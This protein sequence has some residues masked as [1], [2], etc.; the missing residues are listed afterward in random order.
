MVA[1]RQGVAS[2]TLINSDRAILIGEP[3]SISFGGEV[4]FAGSIDRVRI[5]TMKTDNYKAYVCECVDHASLMLRNKITAN[6]SNITVWSLAQS[7]VANYLGGDGFTMG[8]SPLGVALPTVDVENIS[9]YDMLYEAAVSVGGSLEIT[10]DKVINFRNA[11]PVPAPMVIDETIVESCE[12][13]FDRERYRNYQTVE[14]TGTPSAQG[15]TVAKVS[16]TATI[17]SQISKQAGIEGTNGVYRERESITHPSSNDPGKLLQLAFAYANTLLAVNGVLSHTVTV[18]VRKVGFRVGQTAT[19]FLPSLGIVGQFFIRSLYMSDSGLEHVVSKLTLTVGTVRQRMQEF[20]LEATR[21]GS[22]T[23]IPPITTVTQSQTFSVQ[24]TYTF[25][26]PAGIT[27][28]QATCYGSGGGAGGPAQSV[29]F[30]HVQYALGGAG[31]RGGKSISIM[32]VTPGQVLTVTVQ[33]GGAGGLGALTINQ[34]SDAVGTNGANGGSSRVSS[35]STVYAE[36]YGGFGGIGARANARNRQSF[37]WQPSPDG[38]GSGMYVTTGGGSHGG[39][40][41][42]ANPISNSNPGLT[43]S[44]TL[45][46]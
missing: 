7:A 34:V 35:G 6:Y 44:V 15:Q 14:V 9:I 39:G 3:V 12:V 38:G 19:V 28:V 31:G 1:D 25:V 16:Y 4:L 26:V 42:L 41:G 30:G 8:D 27:T 22:V 2:F 20:W 5:Q 29:Y 36:A 37:S 21:K 43:G 18:T 33:S 24:G 46:W 10:Y 32:T 23:I 11:T 45:E 17:G 40:S 13:V